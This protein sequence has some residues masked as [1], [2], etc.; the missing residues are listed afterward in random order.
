MKKVLILAYDFYPYHSIAAQRPFS[1]LKYFPENDISVRVVTRHWDRPILTSTDCFLPSI[2]QSVVVKKFA[3][4]AQIISVPFKPNLRDQILLKY[5]LHRKIIIRKILSFFLSFGKFFFSTIDETEAI[6][7]AAHAALSIEKADIIIA[8]G[9]PFILFKHAA[10]LSKEFGVPWIADYR[11]CWTNN[12]ALQKL[13]SIEKIKFSI[14][15][16]IEKKLI[17]K[18]FWLTTPSPSY[19]KKLLEIHPQKNIEVIYN[20]YDLTNEEALSQIESETQHFE[21]AYAGIFY[22]HQKLELFLEGFKKWHSQYPDRKVKIIFYGL[23]FYDQ[24]VDRV[25]RCAP[26]IVSMIEVTPRYAYDEVLLKLKKA[27]VLL[28]LSSKGADW[29]NAKV[30]DYL[31]LLKP[32]LLVQNDHGILEQILE[33]TNTAYKADDIEEVFRQLEDLYQ[34]F[35]VKKSQIHPNSSYLNYSRKEQAKKLSTLIKKII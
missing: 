35:Y 10:T 34:N 13:N 18:A 30:F 6:Y 31:A 7:K 19:K 21:I 12:Y 28:L 17:A 3:P 26:E 11:D 16:S 14:L 33:Q 9:E 15:K 1:W 4:H 24:M 22:P 25:M 8:T 5:G 20:G 29:L 32:V 2:D 27:H 23:E